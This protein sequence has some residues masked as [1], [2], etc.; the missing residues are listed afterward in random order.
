MSVKYK[1]FS[2]EKLI[3]YSSIMENIIESNTSIVRESNAAI[4]QRFGTKDD[5][6]GVVQEALNTIKENRD[7]YEELQKELDY[8]FKKEMKITNGIRKS[9]II[10]DKFHKVVEGIRENIEKEDKAKGVVPIGK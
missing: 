8:R 6:D 9:Q 1:D 5:F 7:K 3:G 4:Q 2:T 10:V